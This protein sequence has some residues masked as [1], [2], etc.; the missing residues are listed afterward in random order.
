MSFQKEMEKS[1]KPEPEVRSAHASRA[2]KSIPLPALEAPENI[3]MSRYTAWKQKW[4]DYLLLNQIDQLKDQALTKAILRQ[5]LH[6]EWIQLWQRE[7]LTGINDES[8]SGM[9]VAS[10]GL[11]L[12]NSRSLILDRMEFGSRDQMEGESTQHYIAA[13]EALDD[14]CGHEATDCCRTAT[15]IEMSG[16]RRQNRIRDRL[17]QGLRCQNTRLKILSHEKSDKLT[18][19]EVKSICQAEEKGTATAAAMTRVVPAVNALKRMSTYKKAKVGALGKCDK[20]GSMHTTQQTCAAEGRQCF[21]C[22]EVGH[23]ARL[24]K[25]KEARKEHIKAVKTSDLDFEEQEE[26]YAE[27]EMGAILNIAE[28]KLSSESQ[29]VKLKV[30]PGTR[31]KSLTTPSPMHFLPDTGAS[32]DAM[33]L[34]DFR[35]LNRL[36]DL[37]PLDDQKVVHAV[38]G[39]RLLSKGKVKLELQY[40]NKKH[41]TWVLWNYFSVNPDRPQ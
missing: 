26:S 1:R 13:L 15:C 11:Y 9:V 18:L 33:G 40:R 16:R 4:E 35:K 36:Y 23:F 8:Q 27:G 41:A 38:N 39:E 12:R 17:I 21:T 10:I 22:G 32:V 7:H 20:C 31:L 25:N 34:E 6:E 30:T 37:I 5:A 2:V 29:L 28:R 19:Q 14:L 24:C 3:T